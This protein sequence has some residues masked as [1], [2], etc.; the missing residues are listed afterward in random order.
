MKL[1]ET[2]QA[3]HVGRILIVPPRSKTSRI[4]RITVLLSLLGGFGY[5]SYKCVPLVFRMKSVLLHYIS[6][7][8]K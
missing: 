7:P 1:W 8:T 5:A 3:E 2:K 6:Q 4:I